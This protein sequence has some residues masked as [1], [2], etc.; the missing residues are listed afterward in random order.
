MKYKTEL[1]F[2][3][4]ILCLC[5]I[6]CEWTKPVKTEIVQK[7]DSVYIPGPIQLKVDTFI[8]WKSYPKPTAAATTAAPKDSSTAAA[9]LCDSIRDY[10]STLDDTAGLVVVDTK[11]QGKILDQKV[12]LQAYQKTFTQLDT[13]IITKTET[14]FRPTCAGFLTMQFDSLGYVKPAVGFQYGRKRVS[15]S[16]SIN[17]KGQ[18]TLGLYYN[19]AK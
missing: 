6:G 17:I 4:L 11:V 19:F 8:K 3:L 2:L 16:G 18:G 12:I 1:L 13:L 7:I 10:Q 15:Y 5:Y 14:K 9:G